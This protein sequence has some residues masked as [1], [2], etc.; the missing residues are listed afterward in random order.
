MNPLFPVIIST[1]ALAASALATPE[2]PV[3]LAASSPPV[4]VEATLASASLTSM[5]IYK[6]L[7]LDLR[8]MDIVDV[9]KMLARQEDLNMVIGKNVS[10]RVTV[11][12]TNV[13]FWQAFKTIL[14]T[15]DLAYSQEGNLIEVMTSSD[16][17]KQY[18]I[19]FVKKTERQ[20]FSL[21]AVT[22]AA[23]KAAL[24]PLMSKVGTITVDEASNSITVEDTRDNLNV[25]SEK[26]PKLDVSQELRVFRLNYASVE[27]IQPKIVSLVSKDFGNLQIDKR[28]NTIVVQDNPVRVKEIADIIHA[29]DVRDKTVLI[30]ARI[31]QLTLS[32]EHQMGVNWQGVNWSYIFNALNG[33]HVTGNLVQNLQLVNQQTVTGTN[34]TAPGITA[35]VGVLEKPNFQA[36]VNA[37]NTI[38]TT[39]LLSCP[40]IMALNGQE[41]KIHVGSKVAK[42]TNTLINAGSTTSAPIVTETVDFL[43]VGVK[44]SVIP[45]ISDE[46]TITMKVKPEVSSVQSTITT[47]DGSSIPVIEV[48][49]AEASLVV[50]DG[51]TV[52]LGGLM[53]DSKAKTDND[54]PFL[55]RI[56]LLGAL[57]RSRDKTEQK[58][59]L[60][61]FLTP[62]IVSGDSVSPEAQDQFDL[63]PNGDPKPKKGF[64]RRL[65]GMKSWFLRS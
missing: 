13:D 18:G 47:S 59:E 30:E 50:K 48:S 11:S 8:E 64:F 16:Y 5:P 51:I 52:V 22:A 17:E 6:P 1:Y 21:I 33:Y 3:S 39:N 58:T 20:T 45:I 44:L 15:R 56:P 4:V 2:P 57:F 25:L 23:A 34:V 54:V 38:G 60:V 35:Q 42:I 63:Q 65:F 49:E 10:G 19:P 36:V 29:M 41:A 12:L 7:S 24:E 32:T 55:G 43:D 40:R 27:D 9:L 61:I 46:N 14:N 31:I 62:H 53:E 28:S 37:L 26:I